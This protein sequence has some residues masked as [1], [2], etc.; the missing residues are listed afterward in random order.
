[1]QW[2]PESKVLVQ[3]L[4]QPLATYYVPQMQAH[5]SQILAGVEP[6]Q[7]GQTLGNI[8]IFDLVAEAIAASPAGT[9]ALSLWATH[10][11]SG[12]ITPKL[13]EIWT[14]SLVRPFYKSDGVSIRPVICSEALM[15]Y[16]VAAAMTAM[17]PRMGAAFGPHQYGA[18]RAGGAERELYE[19]RASM[20]CQDTAS[21]L[22]ED[23]WIIATLDL[24]NAFGNVQW[25]H[26]LEVAL[27]RCPAVAPMLAAM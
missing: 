26:T 8:A 12:T 1:M 17:L 7:G 14:P 22:P 6:G 16:A 15:K 23:Q 25:A 19:V 11:S 10:W 9:Q 27:R 13:A 2:T 24:T 3:G 21:T 18:G 4:T 20:R 5:G